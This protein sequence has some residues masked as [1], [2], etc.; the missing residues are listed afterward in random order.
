MI[1]FE[2]YLCFQLLYLPFCYSV[3][4]E[5]NVFNFLQFELTFLNQDIN[6]LYQVCVELHRKSGF[7]LRY[8]ISFFYLN[9]FN[10]LS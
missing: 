6:C 2:L 7:D 10:Q 4:Y 8:G 5:Y 9:Y 1:F 3:F